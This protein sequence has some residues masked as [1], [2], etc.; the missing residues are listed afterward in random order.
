VGGAAAGTRIIEKSTKSI[1][2][3]GLGS[4]SGGRAGTRIIE[5][6]LNSMNLHCVGSGIGGRLAP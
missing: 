4:G 1:N 3:H 5:N 6:Q 2:L